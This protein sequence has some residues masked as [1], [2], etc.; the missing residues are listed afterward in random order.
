MAPGLA[1]IADAAGYR[2][3]VESL[4]DEFST[5]IKVLL[6]DAMPLSVLWPRRQTFEGL[7]TVLNAPELTWVWGR[8]RDNRLGLPVLQQRRRAQEDARR[9]LGPAQ[10][11]RTGRTQSVLHAAIR[12]QVLV[13]NTLGRLWL[14]MQSRTDTIDN[15]LRVPRA[16]GG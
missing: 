8:G 10:Q 4:F 1:L 15:D 2:L 5:E 7:L 11:P 16:L 3:Y 9:K 12:C 14:E 13:D 6:T